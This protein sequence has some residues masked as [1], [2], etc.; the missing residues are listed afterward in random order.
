MEKTVVFDFDGVIHSYTSGWKGTAVIP[1]PPVKGIEKALE[2]IRAA[3]YRVVVVSSRCESSIGQIAI[4]SWLKKNGLLDLVDDICKEKP[5]AIAYIDDRAICFD[6]HPEG[7]LEKIENLTPWWRETDI[8]SVLSRFKSFRIT[9]EDDLIRRGDVLE[10]VRNACKI[11]KAGFRTNSPEGRAAMAA[12]GA[13]YQSR[14]IVSIKH[15][16]ELEQPEIYLTRA[17][18]V[19]K[20]YA[21]CDLCKHAIEEVGENDPCGGCENKS[22]WEFAGWESL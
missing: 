13:V 9:G 16:K 22:N 14:S 4:K 2:E 10:A 12:L 3:G 15:L 6:G 18:K 19:L 20:N 8:A 5:P 21:G 17:R 1:D 7:L 11:G